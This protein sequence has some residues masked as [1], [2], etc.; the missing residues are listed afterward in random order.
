MPQADVVVVSR[1]R[2][3]ELAVDSGARPAIAALA[4]GHTGK[5]P[6]GEAEPGRQLEV[7]AGRTHGGRHQHSVEL[8]LERLLD[9]QLVGLARHAATVVAMREHLGGAPP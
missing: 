2:G 7:V 3:V 9:D 4:D 1:G 8:D 6:L 5:Q